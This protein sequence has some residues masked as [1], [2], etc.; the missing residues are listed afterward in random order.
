MTVVALDPSPGMLVQAR[1]RGLDGLVQG[2]AENLPFADGSFD[3]VL[4]GYALRHVADLRQTFAQYRRVLRPGG[5]VVLLEITR[6]ASRAVALALKLYLRGAVPALARLGG[7]QV[8]EL[9]QYYWDTIE[10]CV[11]PA[12]I[13]G[14]LGASGFAGARRGVELGIFSEYVAEAA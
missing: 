7:R 2:N 3:C 14:A 9:M 8:R 10:A 13:L 11:E 4:M 6:P 5:R 12:T 1:R